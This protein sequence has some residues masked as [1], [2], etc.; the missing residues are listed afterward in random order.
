M[1]YTPVFLVHV[2]SNALLNV[3]SLFFL[4]ALFTVGL[5]MAPNT[6]Y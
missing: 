2:C 1:A 5:V 6:L 4:S 3:H